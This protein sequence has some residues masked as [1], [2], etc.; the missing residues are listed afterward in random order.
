MHQKY[1][2][3]SGKV[4]RL[5]RKCCATLK[6]ILYDAQENLIR[7]SRKSCTALKKILYG[8]QENIFVLGIWDKGKLG[9]F[10]SGSKV[11]PCSGGV[12]YRGS[13]RRGGK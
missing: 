2:F 5:T 1:N 6:K 3:L 4:Y 7:R 10:A 12:A 8:A 9:K 11:N 13:L